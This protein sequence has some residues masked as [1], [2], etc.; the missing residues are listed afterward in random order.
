FFKKDFDAS[1]I[2]QSI[3]AA[4]AIRVQEPV[5]ESQTKTKL[6]SNNVSPGGPTI[7]TFIN[8]FIKTELDNY[9]HKNP[10]IAN[11]LLKRILQSERERKEISGIKKL[12]NERAKKAN[13]HNKKLRDCRVHYDDPK[14]NVEAKNGTMLF[15]TEGDS[16]SGSITKSRNVQTQAVFSL[17]GK[18]LNCYGMTKKVV[19]ENEEFNL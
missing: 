19:Y 8:D 4:L 10:V 18:P 6:G 1:D 11:D 13:L 14:A 9:L 7:R 15:I 17:R 16:A 2:R 5:F 3:V 12:A